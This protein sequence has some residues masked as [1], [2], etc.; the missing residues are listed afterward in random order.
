MKRILSLLICVSVILSAFTFV[1]PVYA[2]TEEEAFIDYIWYDDFSGSTIADRY[3]N[4]LNAKINTLDYYT[5]ENG[6]LK[7][8]SPELAYNYFVD[9]QTISDKT[10]QLVVSYKFKVSTTSSTNAGTNCSKLPSTAL[11]KISGSKILPYHSSKSTLGTITADTWTTITCVLNNQDKTRDIYINNSYV[12]TKTA[13]SE[14]TTKT[15]QGDDFTYYTDSGAFKFIN[16]FYMTANATYEMDD[17]EIYYLPTELKYELESATAEEVKLNL[18]MIPDSATVIPANFTVK[19]GSSTITPATATLSAVDPRQVILT[20]SEGAL[21]A[22]TTYTVSAANLTA[23]NN[24]GDVADSLVL[25]SSPELSF[26]VSPAEVEWTATKDISYSS[27]YEDLSVAENIT[28]SESTNGVYEFG[29]DGLYNIEEVDGKKVLT[30]QQNALSTTKTFAS[31]LFRK[32]NFAEGNYYTLEM[33][34]KTDFSK[35]PERTMF[36]VRA[37]GLHGVPFTALH[38]GVIYTNLGLTESVGTYNDGEWVTLK[39]VY[40]STPV[41]LDLTDDGEDNPTDMLRRD[42][43]ING[44][45]IKTVYDTP[46]SYDFK[47]LT[48]TNNWSVKLRVRDKHTDSINTEGKLYIDYIRLYKTVDTFAAQLS[49]ETD[50]DTGYISVK[51]NNTPV[52]AD[53]TNTEKIYVEDESGNKVSAIAVPE[54]VNEFNA[55]GY[56]AKVNLWFNDELENGKT[57]KLCINGVTDIK[58][59]VL[60]QEETFTTKT[61]PEVQDLKLANGIASVTVNEYSEPLTLYVVGYDVVEGVEQMTTVV[62]KEITATGTYTTDTKVTEDVVKAFLWKGTKPVI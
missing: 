28:A 11:V 5:L 34:V 41:S 48:G 49:S 44:Q 16:A 55:E 62:T 20:F 23:G 29:E 42:I 18:N 31:Y 58:G 46:D 3:I 30:I 8:T 53:L 22:G 33:K 32:G 26:K 19:A 2:S 35:N 6:V 56:A 59:N 27:N 52:D 45:F 39:N 43:Y 4:N 50:V 24:D 21:T 54:F 17:Y 61:I 37:D 47:M 7:Y 25:T 9:N 1:M 40:Y 38:N 13:D 51:F 36:D 57:Y 10:K 14:Y 60:Y 12:G 15:E